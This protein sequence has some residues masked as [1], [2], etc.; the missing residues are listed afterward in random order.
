M[1]CVLQVLLCGLMAFSWQLLDEHS[2]HNK[3]T[4]KYMCVLLSE[5]P[6]VA[7]LQKNTNNTNI[8]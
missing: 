1:R 7:D 8:N 6:W 3:Q 4:M 5:V 2:I